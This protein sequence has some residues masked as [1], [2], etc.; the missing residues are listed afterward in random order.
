MYICWKHPF[1]MA[2]KCVYKDKVETHVLLQGSKVVH[3]D[4]GR[5]SNS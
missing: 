5:R 1:L 3:K 2:I 4:L